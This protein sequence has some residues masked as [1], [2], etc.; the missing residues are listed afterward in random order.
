MSKS[1][2]RIRQKK[3]SHT[4]ALILVKKPFVD[5]I[6]ECIDAP[7]FQ[8]G[9]STFGTKKNHRQRGRARHFANNVADFFKS[10]IYV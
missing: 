9:C 7:K 4:C 10:V 2:Y 1:I 6:V 8:K 3:F 5:S